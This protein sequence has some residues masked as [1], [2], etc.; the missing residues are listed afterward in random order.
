LLEHQFGGEKGLTLRSVRLADCPASIRI[1]AAR[2][3]RYQVRHPLDMAEILARHGHQV[4]FVAPMPPDVVAKHSGRGF[5][6]ISLPNLLLRFG[7]QY[8]N[9]KM[10][11]LGLLRGILK[12]DVTI[13]FDPPG[14]MI[15]HL[16]KRLQCTKLL[17]YYA[18]ELC[19]P[20]ETWNQ[21]TVRYQARYVQDA[22]LIITTGKHR[23]EIMQEQFRLS[24][25]PMVIHNSPMLT[26]VVA[27]SCLRRALIKQGFQ[28]TGRLVIYH[29][30]LS[31]EN[32]IP[33][34]V[35]SVANWL[36]EAG[37]VLIGFGHPS[38]IKHILE[39]AHKVHVSNRIFYLGEVPSWDIFPFI[40]GASL[41][42]VLKRYR[43][44]PLNNR[45]YTPSK[46]FEYAAM[47]LPVVCSNQESLQFVQKEGW[48]ICVDPEKPH[49]IAEAVNTI[50]SAP[51]KRERMGAIAR[52]MFVEKYAFEK[53]V[54]PFEDWLQS[55]NIKWEE[56]H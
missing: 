48:G 14:F 20:E 3:F 43:N 31:E 51:G 33:Q 10:L 9:I 45:F 5:K 28:P 44:G 40:A 11:G 30:G 42:L 29:G 13:G 17:V 47:S 56:P 27:N 34:I 53:Q 23:A 25:L 55:S 4:E 18:M 24:N 6:I 22:D 50:L 26:D 41:G 1:I 37:L 19:L 52:Q 32:A 7:Q 21:L 12:T 2:D 8:V 36:P 49:E 38:F 16:L 35:Q 15:A 46:L 54:V 39:L